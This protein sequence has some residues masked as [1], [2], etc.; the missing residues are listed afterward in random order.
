MA[1]PTMR[2]ALGVEASAVRTFVVHAAGE[3][4]GQKRAR[5]QDHDEQRGVDEEINHFP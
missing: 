5:T 1:D 2:S 3:G 4:V